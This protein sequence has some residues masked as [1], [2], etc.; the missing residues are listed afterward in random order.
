MVIEARYVGNRGHQLWHQYNLN[1]TDL[2]ENNFLN[3]VKLAQQNLIAN[4]NAGRGLQF[5]YQG[6]G[7]GTSP[8]PNIYGY[9]QGVAPTN[10]GN[11][12]SIA[13]CNTLYNSTLFANATFTTA[14]NPLSGS[15]IG[16]ANTI[17]GTANESLF[18]PT[19]IT[20]GIPYNFFYVN[21]G[22]RG[23]AFL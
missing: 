18:N 3:E 6:P 22:K 23:G 19:R 17:G 1:E 7:T 2:F 14:L 16:F 5:R 15:A 11:C 12:T 9:F 8:L 13:T 10:A 4:V 20:A 21:P